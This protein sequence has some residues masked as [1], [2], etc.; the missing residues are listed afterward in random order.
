MLHINSTTTR[1]CP[2]TQFRVVNS[3]IFLHCNF[4]TLQTQKIENSFCFKTKIRRVEME[5]MYKFY[6]QS[7]DT[8]KTCDIFLLRGG[9][10]CVNE[11]RLQSCIFTVTHNF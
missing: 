3:V 6:K 8:V 1:D 11:L 7:T 2:K 10:V 5:K 4:F 9:G